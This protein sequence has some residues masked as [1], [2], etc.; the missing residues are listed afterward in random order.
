MVSHAAFVV[1][2]A[3]TV[4]ALG[5]MAPKRSADLPQLP[6]FREQGIALDSTVWGGLAVRKGTP[7]SVLDTL[8][9]ACRS[10][11]DSPKLQERMK[12]LKTPLAYM[13]SGEFTTFVTIEYKRKDR[14]ST[15]TN[16]SH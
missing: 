2:H 4:R 14:K 6:T 1:D 10:A 16:S 11:V 8:G 9:K 12:K 7:K 3:E 5:I 13:D 15:R